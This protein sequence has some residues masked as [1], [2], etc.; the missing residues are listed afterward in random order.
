MASVSCPYIVSANIAVSGLGFSLYGLKWQ[1]T[2]LGE[3]SVLVQYR[4][5]GDVTWINVSTNL[6]VDAAGNITVGSLAILATAVQNTAYEVRFV[7][8]CGSL[9]YIQVF[10]YSV[11]IFSDMYLLDSGVYNICGTDPI[12]LYSY[13]PF[14]TGVTMYSDIELTTPATGSLYI[15][16][17]STGEIFGINSGTGVVGADTTYN[18]RGTITIQG[19]ASNNAGTICGSSISTFYSNEVP[20]IGST[21][22]TDTALSVPL[23]GFDYLVLIG[24]SIIYTLNNATGEI[25]TDSGSDCTAFGDFY[26]YSIVKDDIGDA[27]LTQ[28]FTSG[29]FGKG[30][31]MYTDYAMTTELTG[32]NYIALNGTIRD[33]SSTTGVVGCLST[34]C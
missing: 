32:Y 34:N 6:K 16:S 4:V 17:V 26:L 30:A 22:Y 7:N 33:I 12:V 29:S 11:N 25:L 9:E 21:L 3:Q 23:T 28:L 20:V 5:Q 31:V 10:R 27:A 14:D 8:Q 24:D 1:Y 19:K 15:S 13:E 18:C 2:P